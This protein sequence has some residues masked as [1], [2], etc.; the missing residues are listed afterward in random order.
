MPFDRSPLPETVTWVGDAAVIDATLQ[1]LGPNGENWWQGGGTLPQYH[2]MCVGQTLQAV[3][4]AADDGSAYRRIEKLITPLG[5]G[6]HIP[7]WN[8]NHRTTFAQVRERLES[9]RDRLQR[10]A[11]DAVRYDTVS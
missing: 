5:Y 1:K 9:V 7:T 6:G 4:G 2:Q 10:E 11:G 8:D 3:L